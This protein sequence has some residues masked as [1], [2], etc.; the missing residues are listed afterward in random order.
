MKHLK[1][2]LAILLLSVMLFNLVACLEITEPAPTCPNCSAQHNKDDL[3]CSN[4]GSN[5]KTTVTCVACGAENAEGSKFCSK[6]G[7][8]IPPQDE[9]ANPDD[10]KEPEN[11]DDNIEPENYNNL[12]IIESISGESTALAQILGDEYKITT[13]GITDTENLPLTV[14]GLSS[15]GCIIL[16][17]ISN[18]DMPTGFV[19]TLHT[20]VQDLGGGLFTVCGN[21]FD[22]DPSNETWQA[23][24]Y[25]RYDMRH[26]LYQKLLPVEIID[27]TPPVAVIIL[28]DSSGSMVYDKA[29]NIIDKEDPLYEAKEVG[30]KLYF[31]K[32]GAEGCLDALSDRDYMGIYSLSEIETEELALTPCTQREKIITSIGNIKGGGGTIFSS[33]LES[34]GNALLSCSNVEK[35]HIIII[36]DGEPNPD[37]IEL[38]QAAL[39]KNAQNGITTSIIGIQ[40]TDDAASL[41]KNLLTEYAGMKKENYYPISN[42]ATV[43]KTIRDDVT[44]PA[45]T[46]VNYETFIPTITTPTPITDGISQEDIPELNGFYGMKA[47]EATE[48]NELKVILSA[49]YTPMYTYWKY[50]KGRVGTFACDLNGTWSS[51]FISSETGMQLIRNMIAALFPTPDTDSEQTDNQT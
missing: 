10:N 12:L 25:T 4:C 3:F 7:E 11:S 34:A 5:L 29:G 47:K 39:L 1:S 18:A 24:A 48:E 23:N 32:Q 15:Y 14:E 33:A 51:E 9:P 36:T 50:G 6:C 27:Y 8:P 41:M 20:Y 49:K 31:A 38:T 37:D 22:E 45:I 28:I 16:C 43:A 46:E 2:A 35:R 19:D 44:A 13:V 42:P 26:T 17:N 30:T 40:S 21:E